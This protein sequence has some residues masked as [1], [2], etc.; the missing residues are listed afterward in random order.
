LVGSVDADALGLEALAV[1]AVDRTE[2]R[3]MERAPALADHVGRSGE[4]GVLLALVATPQ[5]HVVAG[6]RF[7][8]EVA[9][10]AQTRLL[11]LHRVIG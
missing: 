8:V 6:L 7:A 9:E 2:S 1:D 10:S 5:R 11:G 3:M 4:D